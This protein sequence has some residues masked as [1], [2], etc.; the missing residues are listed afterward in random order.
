[1]ARKSA[2]KPQGVDIDAANAFIQVTPQ[3]NHR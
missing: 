2:A 3:T 1:M